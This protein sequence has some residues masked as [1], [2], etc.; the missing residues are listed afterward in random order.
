MIQTNKLPLV[1]MVLLLSWADFIHADIDLEAKDS[2]TDLI[3]ATA[4]DDIFGKQPFNG[5][6][7]E[8]QKPLTSRELLNKD[9][10]K[11][12]LAEAT[13]Q[14]TETAELA[15]DGDNPLSTTC[16]AFAQ[17][18]DA[19]LGEII[20]AGCKPSTAQM[21]ALMDNPL[22]NVA[23]MLNQ[24]DIIRLKNDAN[25]KEKNQ[26]NFMSIL[27][28]PKA[29]N[30]NWNLINRIVFNVPSSPIDQDKVDQ[31]GSASPQ[32]G[33][34]P[35]LG[36][37]PA[38]IDAI[39]G[40]T[41]GFG[42]MYYVGLFAPKKPTEYENLAGKG[43]WGVGFDMG[44]PTASED[45]LGANKWTAG[46]SALYAYLG[47][48][49][50]VGALGQQY[51]DFA[52]PSTAADVNLTNI[53]YLYYYS[54]SP[55]MSIGA[56]PN[57]IIDWEQSSGNRVTLP[58]GLGINKTVNIGKVPVRFAFEFHYSAIKPDDIPGADWDIRLNIIPAAPS[59]L[60]EW[61]TKPL[62]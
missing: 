20:R 11:L 52:G 32:S 44:F 49:W 54:L 56:A 43:V 62:F 23:M 19:D 17:D 26:G 57:V 38:L 8:K 55:T 30:K 48:K 24:Y 25:G 6:E 15:E 3:P 1:V 46:P 18:A 31:L 29:V 16:A 50:K 59:A 45:V 40:R 9:Y 35:P 5:L 51:W 21:S 61:M 10:E 33:P 42:D 2:T 27:Q 34:P 47:P 39:G 53:Q 4:V 58:I 36:T 60:F 41:D 28:F 12:Y 7:T 37:P 13:E 14:V 22:G